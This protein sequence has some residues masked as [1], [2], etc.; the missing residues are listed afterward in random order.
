MRKNLVENPHHQLH[1]P[2][3]VAVAKLWAAMKP[4]HKLFLILT[5]K[6]RTQAQLRPAF[7]TSGK[8]AS[9]SKMGLYA[10]STILR[11]LLTFR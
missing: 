6:L 11:M 1:H 10:D 9:V 5:H 4:L 8:M 3:S 2:D 7:Y